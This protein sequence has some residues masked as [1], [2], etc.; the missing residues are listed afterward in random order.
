MTETEDST[1][2]AHISTNGT[3][4]SPQNENDIHVS[5]ADHKPA[6]TTDNKESAHT[7]P[8]HLPGEVDRDQAAQGEGDRS[9]TSGSLTSGSVVDDDE[10]ED[11]E[12]EECGWR[13]VK[14]GFL[15]RFRS[16][17]WVLFCLCWAG[18]LQGMIVNGFVSVVLSSIERRYDL[19][20]SV[21]G[22][23]F[24]MYDVA[25]V[26][27][28]LPVSYFGGIGH[29]PRWLGYGVLV[30]GI[31]SIVFALPHF[32]TGPYIVAEGGV[33]KY[34][35]LS[36]NSTS[37]CDVSQNKLSD[38]KYVFILAQLLHGAGATPLYTL[39]VTYLDENLK[40][41]LTSLYVGIYYTFAIV[42]PAIGF[43]AGGQFL[44][45]YT[46]PSID[47]VSL[48]QY[49]GSPTWVG[50]WWIGFIFS[51]V[52]GILVAICLLGFPKSL[53]GA[54]KL[55]K[56]RVSEA[57]KGSEGVR[58][59]KGWESLKTLPRAVKVLLLNPT[60]M[61]LNLAGASE[62]LL[63]SGFTAFAP[64]FVEYQFSLSSSWAAT[65]VGFAV[66]PAGGGGTFLGGYFV[67][68]FDL[69]CR[70]I[71]KLCILTTIMS[72]L[73]VL[74][75]L[76]Q[77]PNGKFAGVNTAYVNSSTSISSVNLTDSCNTDCG[78]PRENYDTVCG[79]DGV[80]YYSPCHAGCLTEVDKGDNKYYYN[81]SCIDGSSSQQDGYMASLGKCESDCI[82]LYI[83][84]PVFAFV[85]LFTFIGSMPALSATLRCVP[86]S[87]KSFALG[88]QWI[89]VRC[90]GTIPA[91]IL[92]GAIIDLTCHLWQDSCGEKG[93]CYVY[94]NSKMGT[95]LLFIGVCGKSISLLLFILAFCLYK[96]PT[97]DE[98]H[99][100]EIAHPDTQVNSNE[101]YSE[102]Q[103]PSEL[104]STVTLVSCHK[105]EQRL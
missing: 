62:G 11:E 80:M 6:M 64:K 92:F 29:K 98:G 78:C 10:D 27:C 13:G 59:T 43:L 28:L 99:S 12:E 45:I 93:A 77:C 103:T 104:R 88:I 95:Y 94:D 81:C 19:P 2:H 8:P 56:L 66:I 67:K 21:S 24:S 100:N 5:D 63:L 55:R 16:P 42:G 71:I 73:L 9:V 102:G 57:Y 34:C 46:D 31:G 23:I 22:T 40:P 44:N 101:R 1:K 70:G 60:Y 4:S 75:F 37:L 3:S 26:I 41:K 72:L 53:P 14:P 74:I 38:Y 54:A 90:L 87:Q 83:F 97:Q 36:Q 89:L 91:G 105:I 79:V 17:K 65:V 85:M 15:Q 7:K 47:P 68:R 39:G 18:A 49:P 96:P 20:S 33:V 51:G 69:K 76:V 82:Y 84:L 50:A 30:M 61:F 25:S 48:K 35:S 58:Q 52:L 86:E 32:T